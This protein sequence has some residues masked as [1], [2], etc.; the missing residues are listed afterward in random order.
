MTKIKIG[1]LFG[2]AS[3][4]REISFAGGRTVY[5]NLDKSI[6]EPIPLFIDS[7]NNIIQLDWKYIYKGSIRD[8]YPPVDQI[9]HSANGFQI[10]VESIEQLDSKKINEIITSVGTKV[11]LDQLGEVIDFAFLALHGVTG[12]DGMIQGMLEFLKIPYSG[13]GILPCAIGI[14]KTVQKEWM[15]TVNFSSKPYLLISKDQ[16]ANQENHS[17]FH[18][19]TLSTLGFPCVVRAAHQGS[20]IG[21][22][23]LDKNDLDSFILQVNKSFFEEIISI[24]N[25]KSLDDIAKVQRIRQITDLRESVGLPLLA[26]GQKIYHPEALLHY[27]NGA[28]S[29]VILQGLD[30]ET[31]VLIE[32]YIHGKEFSCIVLRDEQGKIVA[33]PPTEIVKGTDLYDYRSKYMPGLSRK[34]T[35]ID[36]PITEIKNIQDE[37]IR[38]FEFLKFDTYARIDGFYTKDKEIFLND[39]NTTSGML[40]SSFFFHQAAEVGWNPSQFLTF[41]IRSSLAERQRNSLHLNQYT[42]LID[43]LDRS[44]DKQKEVAQEKIKVGV[45]LGGYSFERHISVESGRNIFEKLASSEKYTPVPIFLAKAEDDYHLYQIPINL[46]LKDNADD[47]Y[48]NILNFEVHPISQAI[49]KEASTLIDKYRSKSTVLEPVKLD[50]NT[51]SKY[52]DRAFIALHGRPGEDGTIQK[53]LLDQHIPFNGSLPHSA[54]MTINK[55]ATLQKLKEHDFL[56]TDQCLFFKGDYLEDKIGFIKEIMQFQAFPFILK[57]VDDGCSSAVAVIKS[58]T[59]L[60]AYIKT[61]FR[62]DEIINLKERQVLNLKINEEFPQKDQVLAEA[63]ITA[64]GAD[65]FLEIT[66]GMITKYVKG[67]VEY[68]VFEPSEALAGDEILS[69]EEKFLAGEGQNITPAR[70]GKS[71]SDYTKIAAQVRSDLQRAAEILEVDSYCRIDAFVRIFNK[72]TIETIIIEINSLPGMTPA[73]AIFHQC[74]LNGYKPFTFIDHILAYGN[75]RNKTL[76]A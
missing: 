44:I 51:L 2:G 35:P 29:D 32:Q 70:F 50:K 12:E 14:S 47:I 6:F 27:L 21:I 36:L 7:L 76:K 68:E 67:N 38:L 56:V 1:I 33:L 61:L 15:P 42:S 17:K 19:K 74:A 18:T 39:P 11:S 75:E 26:N 23:I 30:A 24:A 3:R 25:W 20:S 45:I 41:I 49:K 34:K 31:Q 37:S 57:P 53:L 52:F 58:E 48:E 28:T 60:N 69:L 71:P 8:F 59:Q 73:T 13:S 72:D 40:P 43:L 63:L 5:D 54:D 62:D 66:G 65:Q 22:S 64:E 46:L 55:Y 10:Y 4:E 16:W 9:P